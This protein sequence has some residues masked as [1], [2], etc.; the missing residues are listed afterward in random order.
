MKIVVL[1]ETP[2]TLQ[3]LFDP[4]EVQH[5]LFQ[6][7]KAEM[8]KPEA[9]SVMSEDIKITEVGFIEPMV[10]LK[11]DIRPE[12]VPIQP[13]EPSEIIITED[14]DPELPAMVQ[15][16][17]LVDNTREQY[18]GD[19]QYEYEEVEVTP[20]EY[21]EKDNL[22]T[23]AVMELKPLQKDFSKCPQFKLGTLS[24]DMVKEE[25]VEETPI[26]EEIIKIEEPLP[27]E[28]KGI[29]K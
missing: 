1:T 13:P 19:V 24:T 10:L 5:E 28:I 11:E 4:S 22:I 16:G 15:L 21:D 18:C 8:V 25:P 29:Q 14:P 17:R 20:A 6:T 27:K 3:L 23:E 9:V 7:A 26:E 12:P 2:P